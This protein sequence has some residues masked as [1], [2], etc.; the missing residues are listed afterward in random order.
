MCHN[1]YYAL[2]H[3]LKFV[4]VFSPNIDYKLNCQC[5]QT[6]FHAC[7]RQTTTTAVRTCKGESRLPVASPSLMQET[8]TM[9]RISVVAYT[10]VVSSV[11]SAFDGAEGAA[12]LPP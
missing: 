10:Y 2:C 11:S 8:V 7:L 1:A 3:D 5:I 6:I 12:K 9:T 4:F